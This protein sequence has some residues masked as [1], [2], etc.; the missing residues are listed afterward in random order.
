MTGRQY[1]VE[2]AAQILR[3]TPKSVR[4]FIGRN[5]LVA[6]KIG[7][8]YITEADLQA[9]MERRSSRVSIERQFMQELS[10]ANASWHVIADY[11]TSDF[12]P[13]REVVSSYISS[14]DLQEQDAGINWLCNYDQKSRRDRHIIW[15][16]RAI[17][18]EVVRRLDEVYGEDKEESQ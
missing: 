15:G 16:S 7:R 18:E 3:V 9:F 8:W 2:E 12:T 10:K 13:A 6:T 1:T 14:L 11:Y 5:E 4:D 17:V